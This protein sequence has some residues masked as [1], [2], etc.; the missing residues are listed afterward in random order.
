G[1]INTTNVGTITSATFGRTF[2]G[3]SNGT[4][5]SIIGTTPGTLTKSGAGTWTL[6]GSNT[7][8]GG[9]TINAGILQLNNA[10]A[11]NSTTANAVTFGASS[12]GKLQLN[13][14]S[15]TIFGLNINA[16]VD[17]QSVEIGISGTCIIIVY[18]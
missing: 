18:S 6:S 8:T 1:T 2:G 17:T 5:P 7:F 3:A 15:Q 16:L 4:V 13:G 9:V 14:L 12:T 11:L 10:G